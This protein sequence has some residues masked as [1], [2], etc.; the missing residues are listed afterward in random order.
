MADIS[1]IFTLSGIFDWLKEWSEVISG[2][3]SLVLSFGL[4][5]LYFQQTTILD[6]QRKLRV[7]ELNREVR[8]NHTETLRERVRMWHGDPDREGPESDNLNLD[9]NLNIPRV[10]IT[11]IESAPA[12]IEVFPKED[13][14]R[15]VPEKLEG[16]RYLEDLLE[17]HAPDL[18]ESKNRLERLEREFR[19]LK[20]EF[21][22][23]YEGGATIE[24]EEYEL[25]PREDFSEW[26]FNQILR[27]ERGNRES[28]EEIMEIVEDGIEN[29]RTHA[30]PDEGKAFISLRRDERGVYVATAP[31][32]E[33]DDIND[34]LEQIR[35]EI[36]RGVEQALHDILDTELYES[37]KEASEKLNAAA[38][39][40]RNL[41]NLLIKYEGQQIYPGDCSYIQE[42]SI[43]EEHTED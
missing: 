4:L 40:V 26:V 6:E 43:S 28:I 18:R 34:N 29:A 41:E 21:M 2:F 37:A 24:R 22:E 9:S 23:E 25:E 16:E 8:R 32:G 7:Q 11:S 42:A 15:V 36:L 35:N 27:L 38:A 14:F 33:Y 13:T 19:E 5:Y 12:E 31:S 30:Q 3:G 10:T 1:L 17:N 39:E 20:N